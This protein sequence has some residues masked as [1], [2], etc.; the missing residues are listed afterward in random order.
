MYWRVSS[1]KLK[2]L[3]DDK[4]VWWGD[5]GNNVPRLKRFLGEVKTGRVPQT[6][7]TYDEVGHTQEAKKEL[8]A[9][10]KFPN[11]DS[12]METPK[13]TRMLKRIL[14]IATPSQDNA[15]VLDFFAGS[16]AMAHATFA[17]NAEDGGNRRAIA[18]Q[19]AEPLGL[20]TGNGHALQTIADICK[21]R[22]RNAGAKI[23][24]DTALTAPNLDTGFRVLKIDTSNM[25]DVY[26][27]PDAVAQGD[28]LAQVDNIKP[29]RKPEDL[30]FQVLVDWGID[31]ALPIADRDHR[32]Q[33]GLLRGY[34]C[35]GRLLRCRPDG[36][37]GEGDCQAETA[38][39]RLPRRQLR[40]G[41][42]QDQRGP[43]L[44]AALS[45]HGSQVNLAA[46]KFR[47]KVQSYQTEAVKAVVDCFDGQPLQ[48]GLGYRIDPGRVATGQQARPGD[49][50]G[51]QKLRSPFAG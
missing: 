44:Q 13:P 5:D 47:F 43:D 32:R 22:I 16:G 3:D 33:A 30:L 41:C 23:K 12:T 21:E 28:L 40:F 38:T 42:C 39:R 19:I 26:Y 35:A 10:V 15:L 1:S 11:S 50:L 48:T 18:V 8:L 31:L 17:I 24:S 6:L 45:G 51:F 20:E 14:Q 4:R 27:A 34:Q 46:M 25:R 9:F 36:R 49:G 7:W 29:D 2:E 37:H